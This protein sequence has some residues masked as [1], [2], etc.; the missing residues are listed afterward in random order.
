MKESKAEVAAMGITVV[1]ILGCVV[2]VMLYLAIFFLHKVASELGTLFMFNN[3]LGFGIY[4]LLFLGL[5]SRS[6]KKMTPA[7]F[8]I[9]L[10]FLFRVCRYSYAARL[11]VELEPVGVA[12]AVVGF[13]LA[14]CANIP[15]W[16]LVSKL[17]NQY[18]E[19]IDREKRRTIPLNDLPTF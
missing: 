15:L 9:P 10:D 6:V 4:I 5:D 19:M 18:L 17:R 11:G 12:S 2:E 8:F 3:L 7:L 14:F 13:L 16:F 1:S